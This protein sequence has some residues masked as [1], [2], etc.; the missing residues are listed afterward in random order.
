MD[1][2]IFLALA[3]WLEDNTA[4]KLSRNYFSIHQKLAIF[5]QIVGKG[6]S[7]RDLQET[8]QHSGVTI[9][10]LFHA[11]LRALL[12]LH[13]KIV[14]LPTPN[15]PLDSRIAEDTKYFPYFENF[16]YLPAHVPAHLAIPYRN[17]RAWLFQNV[18]G[19]CQMDLIFCYALS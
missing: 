15:E 8:F 18:L 1:L 19:E 11:I 13:E 9:S 3:V 14:T 5:L 6:N 7:N 2:H 12:I 16:I 4:L 17:R 10:A